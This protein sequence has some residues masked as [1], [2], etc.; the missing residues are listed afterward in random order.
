MDSL[1]IHPDDLKDRMI[2]LEKDHQIHKMRIGKSE[3]TSHIEMV[4]KNQDQDL[5]MMMIS[6]TLEVVTDPYLPVE[7]K[8]Q[9]KLKRLPN[10]SSR[11]FFEIK[12]FSQAFKV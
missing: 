1:K 10:N 7:G 6:Q 5:G 8:H 2:F 11:I 12:R 4:V 9:R 3:T